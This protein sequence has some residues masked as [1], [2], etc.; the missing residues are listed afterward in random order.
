MKG[1][2]YM[3]DTTNIRLFAVNQP[4]NVENDTENYINAGVN[5]YI[6]QFPS[7]TGNSTAR[8][9]VF[10]KGSIIMLNG[11][12]DLNF[13]GDFVVGMWIKFMPQRFSGSDITVVILFEDGSVS[14]AILPNTYTWTDAH[15]LSIL[16][17]S[18][19][20][21]SYRVDGTVF[22]TDT[23]TAALNLGSQSLIAIDAFGHENTVGNIAIVDDLV[24]ADSDITEVS[25]SS[26]PTNYLKAYSFD[27]VI[28]WVPK[29]ANIL[30]VY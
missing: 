26:N 4:I 11:T 28:P 25:A 15:Y 3:A 9:A 5:G 30:K 13:T 19:G 2:T 6:G 10:E 22:E 12:K 24:I 14:S 27:P 21:I 18:S 23:N 20:N 1:M 8:A 29:V 16:R 17:D 7:I